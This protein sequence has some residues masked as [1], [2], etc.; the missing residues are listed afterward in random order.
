M[1]QASLARKRA[2]SQV[3]GASAG[4]R[5]F[6]A[7]REGA[8]VSESGAC[9]WSIARAAHAPGLAIA[10]PACTFARAADAPPSHER[11]SFPIIKV[12]AFLSRLPHVDRAEFKSYYETRHAPMISKLMP[13][14]HHYERNYPDVSRLRP[15]EGKTVDD[16]VEFDA[17]TVMGFEDRE[18]FD[19]WKR[20]LKD[21]QILRVIR[22]DEAKFL[23]SRK[24]RLFVVESHG[25]DA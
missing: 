11:R 15:P 16:L 3:T 19:A 12:L 4:A 24:T 20:A 25:G 2:R 5:S 9:G 21:P 18:A 13:M 8:P 23:D 7:V 1:N 22:E 6:A 17:V 10:T 14:L